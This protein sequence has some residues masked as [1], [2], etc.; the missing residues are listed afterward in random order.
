M[1]SGGN[2]KSY[3]AP[4]AG[5]ANSIALKVDAPISAPV[6]VRPVIDMSGDKVI[7][8]DRS[9]KPIALRRAS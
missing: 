7:E 5:N 9:G 1:V 3:R 8:Y 6:T 2:V 4:S